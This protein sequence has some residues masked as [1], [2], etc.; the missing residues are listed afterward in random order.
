MRRRSARGRGRGRGS[1]GEGP[2][3]V[4]FHSH[5]VFSD[6]TLSPTDLVHRAAQ[7][8]VR[9]DPALGLPRVESPE[10]LKKER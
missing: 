2:P 3:L 5:S 10:G 4:E 9:W 7:R 1:L 6:G 8:Q